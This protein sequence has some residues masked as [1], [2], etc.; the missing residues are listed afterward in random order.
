MIDAS[1]LKNLLKTSPMPDFGTQPANRY[2]RLRLT[3]LRL[4]HL[5]TNREMELQED[6]KKHFTVL[7]RAS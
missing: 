3:L 5:L 4:T 1:P 6:T 7:T 2:T